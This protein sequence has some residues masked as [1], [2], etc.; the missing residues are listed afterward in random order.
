MPASVASP[1]GTRQLVPS[2]S[3]CA[4]M[5][6]RCSALGWNTCSSSHCADIQQLACP[7]FHG[8]GHILPWGPG[9]VQSLSE[10]RRPIRVVQANSR[11]NPVA[12]QY[13][14]TAYVHRQP[15]AAAL[16]QLHTFRG[17]DL[18]RTEQVR[19]AWLQVD[20]AHGGHMMQPC[21]NVLEPTAECTT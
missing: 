17:R 18:V 11:G 15:G 6:V 12:R 1:G 7:L 8:G 9:A 3:R 10:G 21:F 14:F 16:P 4:R 13:L 5:L 19:L 2:L 20:V